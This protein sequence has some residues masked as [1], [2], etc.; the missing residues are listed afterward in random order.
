MAKLSHRD[1][2]IIEEFVAWPK[3]MGYVLDYT[4][5]SFAKIF[6]SEFDIDIYQDG[7]AERGDSKRNR[8]IS[9][10]LQESPSLVAKVLEYLLGDAIHVRDKVGYAPDKIIAG[11]FV[12]LIK[13][14]KKEATSD[15]P[16]T[17]IFETETADQDLNSLNQTIRDFLNNNQPEEAVDRLHVYC[18]KK[19]KHLLTENQVEYKN[20]DKLTYLLGKYREDLN[21]RRELLP[22]SQTIMRSI[23][24]ILDKFNEA[25]NKSSRSHDNE[26]PSSDEAEFIVKTVITTLRF[27]KSIEG[28]KFDG[29]RQLRA[30][31]NLFPLDRETRFS[32]LDTVAQQKGPTSFFVSIGFEFPNLHPELISVE[33]FASAVLEG[34]LEPWRKFIFPNEKHE[35][36]AI[37]DIAIFCRD[38]SKIGKMQ[39]ILTAFGVA[40]LF[41]KIAETGSPYISFSYKS[42]EVITEDFHLKLSDTQINFGDSPPEDAGGYRI[43][44]AT[45]SDELLDKENAVEMIGKDNNG[46]PLIDPDD[47][48][49]T[50]RTIK[51]Y[52]RESVDEPFK[53]VKGK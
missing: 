16:D 40:G 6:D 19:I 37:S 13:K 35:R 11:K 20:N 33:H 43:P 42:A 38:G 27:I 7:Y 45:V 49:N 18:V 3:G 44:E 26:L 2:D 34:L 39:V 5:A 10:C 4:N 15:A 47:V 9:F 22:M 17:T 25:R 28:D 53:Q 12:E 31:G 23:G 29:V 24:S 50:D 21:N 48:S 1:I 51:H 8:L 41:F 52:N 30:G 36:F 14:L 46:E 32:T